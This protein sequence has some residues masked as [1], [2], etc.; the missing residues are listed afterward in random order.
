MH[1]PNLFK[2][3]LAPFDL[4]R[5]TEIERYKVIMDAC[6]IGLA[7]LSVLLIVAAL[8]LLAAILN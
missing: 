3:E 7:G 2:G 8:G 1:R 6:V 5:A 4:A